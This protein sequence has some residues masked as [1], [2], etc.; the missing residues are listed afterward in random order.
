MCAHREATLSR[1]VHFQGC[2]DKRIDQWELPCDLSV[3]LQFR[4]VVASLLDYDFQWEM[5]IF[6]RTELWKMTFSQL[7]ATF[8]I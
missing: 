8:K 6:Q 5:E 3:A 4:Y 7:E 2:D 1:T